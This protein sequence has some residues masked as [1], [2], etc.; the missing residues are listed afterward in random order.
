MIAC[1]L[2]P[3]PVGPALAGRTVFK[4]KDVNGCPEA[5]PAKISHTTQEQTST[6]AAPHRISVV[7]HFYPWLYDDCQHIVSAADKWQAPF[8]VTERSADL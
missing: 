7:A 8:T 2:D 4:A 6:V 3:D 1:K 5:L